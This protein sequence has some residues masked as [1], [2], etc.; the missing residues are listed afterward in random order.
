MPEHVIIDAGSAAETA[1]AAIFLV[2]VP[3][4]TYQTYVVSDPLSMLCYRLIHLSP[5]TTVHLSQLPA[6]AGKEYCSPTE[7]FQ[8]ALFRLRA[9]SDRA[10]IP[11][12]TPPTASSDQAGSEEAPAP[13]PQSN[14]GGTSLA[15]LRS[16]RAPT[17]AVRTHSTRCRQIEAKDVPLELAERPTADTSGRGPRSDPFPSPTKRVN[18]IGP[19]IPTPFGRRHLRTPK[20]QLSLDELVPEAPLRVG[21]GKLLT[22]IDTDMYQF[23]FSQYGRQCFDADWRTV[24][25]V[26]QCARNFLRGLPTLPQDARPLAYQFYVD[27]SSYMRI[28]KSAGGRSVP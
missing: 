20:R 1:A 4:A 8:G 15:H 12:D 22:G 25:D 27:G 24:R 17:R 6:P 16:T 28:P 5:G 18:V 10:A 19:S 7:V 14:P 13:D 21:D 23:L 11:N 3:E 2:V 9:S 26:P